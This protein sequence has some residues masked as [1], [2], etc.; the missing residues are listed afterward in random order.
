MEQTMKVQSYL[1]FEGRCE[2]ALTF[3][4]KALG[5]EVGGLMRFKEQPGHCPEGAMPAGSEDKILHVS[6]RVG[7]TEL[8]AS[9]GYCSGKPNFQGTGQAI[10][11]KTS[12]EAE[13]V[14]AALSDGGKILAPIAKTFFSPRF[15]MVADRFGVMWMVLAET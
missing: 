8:L 14:F 6:F 10:T 13:K 15:G 5:A 4:K 2:E 11:V 3:Y 9:D 7:D 12:D 1:F